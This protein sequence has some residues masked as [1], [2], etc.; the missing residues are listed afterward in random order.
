MNGEPIGIGAASGGEW[1]LFAGGAV[2]TL[3]LLVGTIVFAVIVRREHRR[4]EQS[5]REGS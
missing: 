1:L 3:A 2:L 4:V 5:E